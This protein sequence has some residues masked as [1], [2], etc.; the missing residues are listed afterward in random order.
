[1]E[2]PSFENELNFSQQHSAQ[3]TPS[4]NLIFFDN[5]RFQDP[6][7]SRCIEVGF[8]SGEP[9]LVWE[10]VLPESMFT[11][12]RGECDRLLTGNSLISAGRTGNV[13]EVNSDNEVVWHLSAENNGVNV[14]IYRTERVNNLFPNIFSFELAEVSGDYNGY[15]VINDGLIEFTIYNHGWATNG[16]QYSLYD[17]W[18]ALIVEGAINENS[19]IIDV[20][21]DLSSLSIDDGA[22]YTLSVNPINDQSRISQIGFYISEFLLG[23]INSDLD[24]NIQDVIELQEL[25]L[26]YTNTSSI[27]DLNNDQNTDIL[28]FIL[29]SLSLEPFLSINL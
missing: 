9:Y 7:H 20:P 29:S 23:D 27:S 26:A 12:S 19:E 5:A 11:G 8:N 3:L 10:H 6:E 22:F 1:M 14:S 17:E 4:G 28:D 24:V 25:I 2:N 16:F 13:M 18:D 21:L 15:E